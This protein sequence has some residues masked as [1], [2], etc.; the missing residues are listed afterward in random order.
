M[1]DTK[2][3]LKFIKIRSTINDYK[4][5]QRGMK[6]KLD[7]GKIKGNIIEQFYKDSIDIEKKLESLAANSKNGKITKEILRLH[8]SQK[9]ISK[10]V[11]MVAKE[12]YNKDL[13]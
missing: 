12:T 6:E 7:N 2:N 5:A 13:E 8:R 9:E 1:I 11:T 10:Y 4:E 3:Y